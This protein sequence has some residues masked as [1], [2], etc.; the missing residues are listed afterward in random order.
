M[1]N[2]ES[3]PGKVTDWYRP[4]E[5][6]QLVRC[7]AEPGDLLEID[8][9]VYKHWAIYVGRQWV[10]TSQNERRLVPCVVHKL[11]EGGG[12]VKLEALDDAVERSRTRVNNT[13]DRSAPV[14]PSE[15]VVRRALL[16]A[17][18]QASEDKHAVD[19]FRRGGNDNF[20]TDENAVDSICS[21]VDNFLTAGEYGYN[22]VTSNCEHFASEMRSGQKHSAQVEDAVTSL[23]IVGTVSLIG[24]ATI[25]LTQPSERNRES[26]PIRR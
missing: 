18:R 22:L 24:A 6:D 21:G 11:S 15:E 20:L 9:I 7:D 23:A 13:I 25:A 17:D 16:A 12:R 26:R 3:V 1:G 2:T 8:R 5:L 4:S 19:I 14:L 10:I